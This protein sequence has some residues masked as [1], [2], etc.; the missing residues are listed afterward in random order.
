[1]KRSGSRPYRARN[2]AGISVSIVV[3]EEGTICP[4]RQARGGMVIILNGYDGVAQHAD[5]LDRGL[6]GVSRP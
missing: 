1:V 2:K 5:S 4:R 6:E 3:F